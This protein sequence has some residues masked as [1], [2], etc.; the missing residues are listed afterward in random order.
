M[1]PTAGPATPNRHSAPHA[2]SP[3]FT[4][5]SRP[6]FSKAKAAETSD[7]HDCRGQPACRK[8]S[9]QRD[10]VTNADEEDGEG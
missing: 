4:E 5:R 8:A 9:D 7:S 1:F 2:R 3:R 10:H 6:E